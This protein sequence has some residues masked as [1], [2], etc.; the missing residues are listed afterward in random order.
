MA[1]AIRAWRAL[2]EAL[3]DPTDDDRI[4]A[5]GATRTGDALDS[6]VD[7][8]VQER[9]AGRRS[10]PNPDVPTSYTPYPDSV[11]VDGTMAVVEACRIGS[12]V[13]VEIGSGPDGGDLVLDDSVNAY[14]ERETFTLI[15]GEWRKDGGTTLELFEGAT[16]CPAPA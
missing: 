15:G 10:V 1:A 5:L 3:Q 9:S 14:H 11:V 4:A 8:I 12:L 2:D 16:A 13:W 6:V 7:L